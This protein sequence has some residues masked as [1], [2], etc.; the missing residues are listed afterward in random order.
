MLR[1][2]EDFCC[3]W[4]GFTVTSETSVLASS[5]V[6][7][8]SMTLFVVHDVPTQSEP[9]AGL[10]AVYTNIP[11]L[12]DV[13]RCRR[14]VGAT[15]NSRRRRRAIRLSALLAHLSLESLSAFFFCFVLFFVFY[16]PVVVS[17]SESSR[18]NNMI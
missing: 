6:G 7:F 2:F 15:H 8:R 14:L 4:D 1:Y 11:R 17:K 10:V 18:I 16:F 9:I 3:C 13:R 5:W 12:H